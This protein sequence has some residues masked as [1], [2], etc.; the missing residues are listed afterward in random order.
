MSL[1]AY[2]LHTGTD[3]AP[4]LLLLREGFSWSAFALAP[5]W[6]L[7]HGLWIATLAYVVLAAAAIAL[8]PGLPAFLVVTSLNLLA[9][10]EGR[11]LRRL[12]LARQG[13]PERAVVLA[14]DE[15]TALWRALGQSDTARA[16]ALRDVQGGWA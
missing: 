9:G 11:D 3:R 4:P 10:Y 13:R 8:V 7:R 1:H 15:D 14:P 16:A 5:L 2:T 6:L 12:R